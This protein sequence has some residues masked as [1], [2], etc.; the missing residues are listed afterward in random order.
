MSSLLDIRNL[1]DLSGV[2][3]RNI[4]L[5]VKKAIE[6]VE[7]N[8]S[9]G[10]EVI[11]LGFSKLPSSEPGSITLSL[12][13]EGKGREVNRY[14]P[15]NTYREQLTI[16]CFLFA[17][18]KYSNI[19]NKANILCFDSRSRGDTE[20]SISTKHPKSKLQEKL[21]SLLEDPDLVGE[22]RKMTVKDLPDELTAVQRQ[23]INRATSGNVSASSLS[24]IRKSFDCDEIEIYIEW[25]KM[26]LVEVLDQSLVPTSIKFRS[27][28]IHE[29]VD[30]IESNEMIQLKDLEI[31]SWKK[32]LFSAQREL[33]EFRNRSLWK[34]I[35]NR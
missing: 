22:Y 8:R 11:G 1:V 15:P 35:L 2:D 34:R 29:V 31:E 32:E 12:R 26:E 9:E 13:R 24:E 3:Y 5:I 16:A 21:T 28:S 6:Y 10:L 30:L 17:V 4:E 33:A 23:L 20:N 25:K 18:A 7:I 19:G 14:S 27:F